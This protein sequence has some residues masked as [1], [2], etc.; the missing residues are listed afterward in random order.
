MAEPLVSELDRAKT[1]N[2]YHKKQIIF[3]EGNQPYGLYCISSGIVK[4][5]KTGMEGQQQIV[6]MAKSGDILG[7]RS[8]FAGENYSATAEVM[9]EGEI[10]FIDKNAIFPIVQRD[11]E[12]MMNI[13]RKLS[14]ELRQAEDQAVGMV[15]KSAKERLAELLLLL[16]NGY[17][18]KDKGG[19]LLDIK[20]TREEIADLIGTTQETAIRILSEMNKEK[21]VE[22]RGRQIV[23]R[24]AGALADIASLPS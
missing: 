17:G 1:T 3:Y 24:D 10:C 8:L 5:Y 19:T 7:Y 13:I 9:E 4:L 6:R 14:K 20:L 23:I 15:Q 22:L 12:T 16:K 11:A 2:Y 21:L 18:K